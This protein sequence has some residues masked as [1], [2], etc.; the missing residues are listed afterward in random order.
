MADPLNKQPTK[1]DGDRNNNKY[2][3]KTI[4]NYYVMFHDIRWLDRP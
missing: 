4:D 3:V 1:H 2:Y